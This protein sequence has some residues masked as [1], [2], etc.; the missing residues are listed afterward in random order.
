[1]RQCPIWAVGRNPSMIDD[2]LEFDGCLRGIT[3][4]EKREPS[5]IEGL[6]SHLR[7]EIVASHWLK[8]RNGIIEIV[9]TDGDG[10]SNA[11]KR[12]PSVIGTEPRGSFDFASDRLGPRRI[13]CHGKCRR[14]RRKIGFT[15]QSQ[16]GICIATH[17]GMEKVR[18]KQSEVSKFDCG[19]LI[20]SSRVQLLHIPLKLAAGF[21]QTSALRSGECEQ[22]A[23]VICCRL[24]VGPTGL[25]GFS[26]GIALDDGNLVKDGSHRRVV[27]PHR[28][29]CIENRFRVLSSAQGQVRLSQSRPRER[30]L[31]VKLRGTNK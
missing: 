23:E 2:G 6:K 7:A 1:M 11:R 12:E 8:R 29:S 25:L 21:F 19:S 28:P 10:G 4:A 30:L 22:G 26:S 17:T 5:K 15:C 16:T 20:P 14:Q 3:L 24:S 18:L 27:Q 13:S 9:L 31:W